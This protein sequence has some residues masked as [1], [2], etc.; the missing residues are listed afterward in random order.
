MKNM[1]ENPPRSGIL[2]VIVPA[3]WDIVLLNEIYL[4]TLIQ[5]IKI[6]NPAA[7][8]KFLDQYAKKAKSAYKSGSANRGL[9]R[10]LTWMY[11]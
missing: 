8:W 7:Y 1:I 4:K 10:E 9:S 3:N 6:A 2:L 5:A 11:L